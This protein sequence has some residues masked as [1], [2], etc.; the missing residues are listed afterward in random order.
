M[1]DEGLP[2]KN[3]DK[4]QKLEEQVGL[5]VLKWIRIEAETNGN[6]KGKGKQRQRHRERQIQGQIN[7]KPIRR[8]GGGIGSCVTR[9]RMSWPNFKPTQYNG[10]CTASQVT[11]AMIRHGIYPKFYTAGFS[12][13]KFYTVNF[14]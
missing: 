13:Q 3:K 1:C 11:S 4:D 6:D 12:G 5:K 14:T 9:I 8:A 10:S 7:G 2:Y